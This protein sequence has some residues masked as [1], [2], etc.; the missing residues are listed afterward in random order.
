MRHSE[1]EDAPPTLKLGQA[2]LEEGLKAA[3]EGLR[4]QRLYEG[5]GG[6]SGLRGGMQHNHDLEGRRGAKV[7]RGDD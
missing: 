4:T 7:M 2:D 5:R 1:S 6:D 3:Q